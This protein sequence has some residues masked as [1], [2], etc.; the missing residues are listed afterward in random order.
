M[1][2]IELSAHGVMRLLSSLINTVV[3]A[4]VHSLRVPIL[5]HELLT[6]SSA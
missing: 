2:Q 5:N 6:F 3:T 4:G 1:Q